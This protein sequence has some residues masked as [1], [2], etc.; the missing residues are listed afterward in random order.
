MDSLGVIYAVS[1]CSS[2]GLFRQQI[3][4]GECGDI[5]DSSW[6]NH[7]ARGLACWLD[8]KPRPHHKPRPERAGKGLR[9]YSYNL[10]PLCRPPH[11][12]RP[13]Q[14]GETSSTFTRKPTMSPPSSSKA[15]PA[16]LGQCGITPPRG[17]T[18]V[19]PTIVSFLSG[20]L[21]AIV[22]SRSARSCCTLGA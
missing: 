3:L 10:Y 20:N 6:P 7:G 19:R 15:S 14:S 4:E 13:E 1:R 8:H 5:D 11:G 18:L 17:S 12:P 2:G 22:A 16:A 21:P 9:P